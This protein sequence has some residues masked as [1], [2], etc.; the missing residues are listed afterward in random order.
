MSVIS[1]QKCVVQTSMSS[2]GE[3]K[4]VVW[5]RHVKK[6]KVMTILTSSWLYV[7]ARIIVLTPVSRNLRV[8]SRTSYA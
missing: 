3:L 7:P 4:G 2:C 5:T 1:V 6:K 8:I